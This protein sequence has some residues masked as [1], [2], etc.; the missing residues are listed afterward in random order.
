MNNTTA[1][2]INSDF[3][4]N[5]QRLNNSLFGSLSNISNH[6]SSEQGDTSIE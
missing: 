6:N 5:N 2:Q 3:E 1:R 4:S